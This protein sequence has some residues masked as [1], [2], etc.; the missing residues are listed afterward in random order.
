MKPAVKKDSLF[1]PLCEKYKGSNAKTIMSLQRQQRMKVE[2][3]SF[4]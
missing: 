2:K 4:G 3:D 1:C